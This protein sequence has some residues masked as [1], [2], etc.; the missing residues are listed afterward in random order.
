MSV[1]R[2]VLLGFVGLLALLA[3]YPVGSVSADVEI[4]RFNET[5]RDELCGIPVTGRSQGI[6]VGSES[7]DPDT[8]FPVF[9]FVERS[10]IVYRN[11]ANGKGIVIRFASLVEESDVV[12]NGDGTYTST[13]AYKGTPQSIRTLDG[14][15]LFRDVGII[16]FETT[17]DSNGTRGDASDDTF[18]SQ[19][20]VSIKGSAP[21][22]AS[23][24]RLFCQK[25]RP[26]LR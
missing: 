22:A 2:R 18:V 10:K 13:T 3:G 11:P 17:F 6:F 14:K 16:V 9:E 25:V 24:F 15:L 4:I 7:T 5:F 23:D 12:D 26:A 21:N 19:R 20:L 1:S 8:G